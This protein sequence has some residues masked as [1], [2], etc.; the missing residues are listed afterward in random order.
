MTAILVN[1]AGLLAILALALVGVLPI[2]FAHRY[3]LPAMS[4]GEQALIVSFLAIVVLV[5]VGRVVGWAMRLAL[6]LL[7][8]GTILVWAQPV[9]VGQWIVDGR[10]LWRGAGALAQA[11]VGGINPA[12]RARI[13]DPATFPKPREEGSN[14]RH[15]GLRH[16][17]RRQAHSIRSVIATGLGHSPARMALLPFGYMVIWSFP[18]G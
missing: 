13:A 6:L 3:D 5:V 17:Q 10:L 8:A 2:G 16:V 14:L 11:D 1:G 7:V 15:P 9:M 18:S 4:Q 12:A